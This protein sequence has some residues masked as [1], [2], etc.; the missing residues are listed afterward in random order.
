MQ[1]KLVVI[2]DSGVGK[3]C[4]AMRFV[5][6]QL[7]SGHAS[8]IG[9]SFLTKNLVYKGT[10]I[11][12]Q[13]WDTA[14]Q[15]RFRSMVPMYYRGSSLAILVYDLTDRMSFRN[16]K[17]WI[18]D[19]QD[20]VKE[21]VAIALVGN[22]ADLESERQV[23]FEEA[24]AFS[25][26]INASFFEVSALTLEDKG[27]NDLFEQIPRTIYEYLM[28]NPQINSSDSTQVKTDDEFFQTRCC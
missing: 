6:G 5:G 19:L 21:D 18:R 4:L 16:V 26:Q 8:T 20:A 17:N 3:T 10:E 22:K 9:A 25:A 14:G 27:T 13:I 2:G 7:P 1:A 28:K 12:L 24:E 15:E 11:N 23:P